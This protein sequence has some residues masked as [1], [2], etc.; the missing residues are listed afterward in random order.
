M[1]SSSVG[2]GASLLPPNVIATASFNVF[3]AETN[4]AIL[5]TEFSGSIS[6]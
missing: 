4:L 2:A 6:L 3:P 5:I 1:A